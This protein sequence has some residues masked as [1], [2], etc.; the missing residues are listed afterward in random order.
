MNSSYNVSLIEKTMAKYFISF[1]LSA[2]SE[3]G[4]LM[5]ERD[6]YIHNKI[7]SNIKRNEKKKTDIKRKLSSSPG[8]NGDDKDAGVGGDTQT[9]AA[10]VLEAHLLAFDVRVGIFSEFYFG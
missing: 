4:S 2:I 3:L 9:N 1:K 10:E 7:T 6:L 8:N 5:H